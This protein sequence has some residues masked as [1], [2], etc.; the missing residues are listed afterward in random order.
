MLHLTSN[1]IDTLFLIYVED[2]DSDLLEVV[3]AVYPVCAHWYDLGLALR[4][5]PSTLDIIKTNEP[6]PKGRLNKLIQAWLSK[7]YNYGKFGNP[8]WR[9]LCAAV[10]SQVG[11]NNPALAEKIAS[12][13][14]SR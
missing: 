3:E 9:L 7:Q 13:H 6:D 14:P 8:S 4:I 10:H 2:A 5:K 1:S 12:A 11:G